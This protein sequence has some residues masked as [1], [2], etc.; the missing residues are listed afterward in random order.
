MLKT[1]SSGTSINT[2]NTHTMPPV[3]PPLPSWPA[4]PQNGSADSKPSSDA[5]DL[6][7]DSEPPPLPSVPLPEEEPVSWLHSNN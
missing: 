6:P 3:E 7:P 4:E 1:Y 5:L 2:S